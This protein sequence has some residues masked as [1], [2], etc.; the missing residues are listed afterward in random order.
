[1]G[2]EVAQAGVFW[3]WH[4]QAVRG[5]GKLREEGFPVSEVVQ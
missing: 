2:A 5:R 1:M 3:T 4:L